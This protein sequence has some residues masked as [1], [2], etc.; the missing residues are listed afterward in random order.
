M[1]AST[2][3]P[4]AGKPGGT[5]YRWLAGLA[6]AGLL[7]ACA[8]PA[9]PGTTVPA[10]T[11]TAPP[12][13]WFIDHLSANLTPPVPTYTAFCATEDMVSPSHVP[14]LGELKPV[15]VTRT[16]F[17]RLESGDPCPSTRPR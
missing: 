10:P 6:A 8:A 1:T 3:R 7:G 17:E 9:G 2:I 11:R 12:V 15:P 14:D 5:S 4:T 13:R 16:D